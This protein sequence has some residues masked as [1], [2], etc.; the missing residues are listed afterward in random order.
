MAHIPVHSLKHLIV[1]ELAEMDGW[2][3]VSQVPW[4]SIVRNPPP[5]Q[6]KKK[7]KKIA[8]PH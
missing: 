7:N 1:Q 2:K 3:V 5:P 8:L 4:R 6:P